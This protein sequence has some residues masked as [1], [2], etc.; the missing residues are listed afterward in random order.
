MKNQGN[1]TPLKKHCLLLVMDHKE[2]D[3]HE[4]PRIFKIIILKMLRE[5]QENIN[6]QCN[7]IR[8]K[9]HEQNKFNKELE[10]IKCT[11]VIL[12]LKSTFSKLKNSV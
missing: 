2:M 10:N 11:T 5:L 1:M 12:E 4:L 9:I 7:K 3:I 8:K 6:E